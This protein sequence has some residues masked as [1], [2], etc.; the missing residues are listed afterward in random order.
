MDQIG[1][2]FRIKNGFLLE[3]HDADRHIQQ[4]TYAKDATGLA[5]LIVA[6]AAR[7]ALGI[8]EQREMFTQSIMGPTQTLAKLN[9]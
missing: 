6:A 9:Q 2:I 3:F 4:V 7:E 5:E 1:K 8:G